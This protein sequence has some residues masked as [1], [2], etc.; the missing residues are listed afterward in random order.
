MTAPLDNLRALFRQLATGTPVLDALLDEALELLDEHEDELGDD[1]R[2]LLEDVRFVVPEIFEARTGP[3]RRAKTN[4]LVA[5][6]KQVL[7]S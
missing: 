1:L 7:G 4:E 3:E 5:R 6:A 2:A